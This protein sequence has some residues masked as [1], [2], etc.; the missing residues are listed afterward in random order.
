MARA[1]RNW[2]ESLIPWLA[3]LFVAGAFCYGYVFMGVLRHV[4]QSH[5]P[6][7]ADAWA[8]N[9]RFAVIGAY[10]TEDGLEG[11]SYASRVVNASRHFPAYDPYIK[12][13]RSKGILVIDGLTYTVMGAIHAVVG[14]INR[15]WIVI[16]FLC[17]LFWFLLIYHLSLRASLSPPFAIFCAVFVTCFS[18]ILTLLFVSQVGWSRSLA[19]NLWTVLSYGRTEGIIRLPRPGVSYAFFFLATFIAVKSAEKQNWTWAIVSGVM[20]GALAYVRLDVWTTHLIALYVFAAVYSLKARKLNLPLAAAA[21]LAT[22]LSLPFLYFTYPPNPEMLLRNAIAFQREFHPYSV[23][24]LLVFALAVRRYG[25]DKP[26][27]LILACESAAMFVMV[28]IELVTGYSLCPEHWM[29]FGNIYVFLLA[30]YFLPARLKSWR[31]PWLA[32]A[33]FLVLVAFLQGIS[34]A[35][36]HFPFQGIPKDYDGAFE[37]LTR[38]A[39][40]DGVVFTLNPEIDIILPLYTRQRPMLAD[41][42]PVVSDYSMV[43][44]SERLAAGM[45]LLDVDADRFMSESLFHPTDLGRRERVALGMVRGTVER[46]DLFQ[47]LFLSTPVPKAR[48]IMAEA[49]KHPAD[50]VPDY[51]W[52]GALERQYAKKPLP[53]AQWREV[54]RNGSVV[55]YARR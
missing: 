54:Y 22:V 6:E 12:E 47:I 31:T 29:Y 27:E 26:A 25:R 30:M 45:R 28:N 15:T 11:P 49:L 39:P 36:I 2:R 42:I 44:N 18:Y 14:E 33:A 34:Y 4:W 3:G 9:G 51:V 1:A 48:E 5:Y 21:L 19:E 16:R 32:G 53:P 35:A 8:N 52:W 41:V 10:G 50:I 46:E 23:V 43:P 7:L 55:L 24:Y 38:N 13:S 37:W 20:G 17:C 40:A